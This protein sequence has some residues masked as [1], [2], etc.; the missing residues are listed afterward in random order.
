MC[1]KARKAMT[2]NPVSGVGQSAD[3]PGGWLNYLAANWKRSCF[4]EDSFGT[5]HPAGTGNCFGCFPNCMTAVEIERPHF[6]GFDKIL[7]KEMDWSF[8]PGS[9]AAEPEEQKTFRNFLAFV[10]SAGICPFATTAVGL[11]DIA[12]L[13]STCTGFD[14]TEEE[15]LQIGE[16]IRNLEMFF[17]RNI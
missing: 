9:A 17:N 16:R 13:Y 4:S 2:E 10:C 11:H 8:E 15:I 3:I 7:K 14:V 6:T 1:L 5:G 12:G